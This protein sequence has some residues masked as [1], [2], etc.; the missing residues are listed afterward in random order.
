M[1]Q[2]F[3]F[4]A[5][6][7]AEIAMH[8]QMEIR[9]IAIHGT[10]KIADF[11]NNGKF[12]V[13]FTRQSLLRSLPRFH[14]A[15][16]KFPAA[17]KIAIPT[18]GGKNLVAILDDASNNFNRFHKKRYINT[19]FP[20]T[21]NKFMKN[22]VLSTC[23]MR[24]L[25][26]QAKQNDLEKG[27][28]LMKQAGSAL[29]R[30][31]TA[32]PQT[33]V[34]VFI[35]GGNNGG[36]GLVLARLLQQAGIPFNVYSLAP[37]EKLKNEAKMALDDFLS[38]RG[39]IVYVG[40]SEKIF[41]TK[42]NFSVVVDCM[43]GNGAQ[44]E[45]RPAFAAAV[46]EINSWNIPVIAA[47]APTGYD[48]AEHGRREPCIVANETMLFGFPRLDA[49]TSEG[50]PV[51][52]NVTVENLD[53]PEDLVA[54]FDEGIHIASETDIPQMLPK[55][56]EWG[57][58]RDQGCAMI[59]A[60]SKDMPGA[61]AL[62]TKAALRSGTG[63]VT[64]ASPDAVMPIL[65]S[66]LT[67]PVFCSLCDMD[68]QDCDSVDDRAATFAPAHIPQILAALRHNQALAIGPGLGS[69]EC[70][71][72]AVL[73]LLGKVQCPTVID[74]DALNAIATLN[75][76]VASAT[77]GAYSFLK[78]IKTA[79][80]LTPHKREFERLFGSLPKKETDIPNHL[81][82]LA[83]G[84]RKTIL[85]KGA[86]TYI[87]FDDERVYV[88]PVSN[89]GMAKGG[90]GDVL[91]GIIVALLAQGM[92]TNEAALLGALLHQKAGECARRDLGSF[93]M[94]PSDVIRRL[95]EAFKI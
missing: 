12:F 16:G 28:A 90:S 54:K 86:P 47:D 29:F 21:S 40:E 7:A 22:T 53:Y 50:G 58:K 4:A 35:G 76:T 23:S 25:D 42:P 66:K 3:Q 64:L 95:P 77:S 55:R 57:E 10:D 30:L 80:V 59:V 78:S 17:L 6:H 36:D 72:T 65:Q 37:V 63:L 11:H 20:P 2:E 82:K 46:R 71:Q 33:N 1:F 69:N 70:T 38:E 67:E 49:Y 81:R 9:V 8:G 39:K 87:A 51:F 93:S 32:K 62:C 56:N 5:H 43:L 19:R 89:S 84:T 24:D 15:A 83:K 94:L 85:L 88:L 61:A 45:L 48:S 13:K 74:A 26:A 75:K 18:L 79:A 52:G 34:A 14:F 60:G 68:G 92:G 41:A 31:V 73:E 91:T 44:G 27:Y